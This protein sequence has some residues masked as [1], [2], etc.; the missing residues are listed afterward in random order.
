MCKA[1]QDLKKYLLNA[2]SNVKLF[3]PKSSLEL[4]TIVLNTCI[5]LL[6]H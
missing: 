2:I 5:F 6:L 3:N 4:F 1:F